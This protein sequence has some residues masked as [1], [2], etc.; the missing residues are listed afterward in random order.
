MAGIVEGSRSH[1]RWIA[2]SYCDLVGKD[3]AHANLQRWIHANPHGGEVSA[4][5]GEVGSG[6]LECM[7]EVLLRTHESELRGDGGQTT[8]PVVYTC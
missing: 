5:A 3:S 6:M 1:L 8:K 7:V 2:K 4:M